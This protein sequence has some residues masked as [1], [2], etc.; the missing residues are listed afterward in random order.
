M[1]SV[2]LS[3]IRESGDASISLTNGLSFCVLPV[4]LAFPLPAL[5]HTDTQ[6]QLHV[7][8][9]MSTPHGAEA[10]KSMHKKNGRRVKEADRCKRALR[11]PVAFFFFLPVIL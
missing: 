7:N 4:S 5:S 10:R 2:D 1:K 9:N 6:K 3:K 11:L 8:I